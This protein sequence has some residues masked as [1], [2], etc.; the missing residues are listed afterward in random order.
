M[1]TLFLNAYYIHPRNVLNKKIS[2][3]LPAS[4]LLVASCQHDKAEVPADYSTGRTVLVYMA[5]QNSLG[6][7]NYQK[8]DS[9]EI[10]NGAAYLPQNGRLLMFIDDNRA[11]RLYEVT[12][13]AKTP[14]LMRQWA[15]D[16]CSTDPAV[17]KDV[18]SY[19]RTNFKAADY[20]LVM[21]SH[22]DGWLPVTDKSYPG[23][24]SEFSSTPT[25]SSFGIDTG[26]NKLSS[27]KGTQMDVSDMAEAI[28]G[29]GMHPK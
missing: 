10:M 22:A 25:V 2:L 27:D 1:F 4:L 21:W 9:L 5:A 16:V 18:L 13:D 20:G 17:L 15:D 29:S 24:T 11:P 8:S 3:I 19:V 26:S 28:I 7:G 6:S 12:K 23:Y 14:K